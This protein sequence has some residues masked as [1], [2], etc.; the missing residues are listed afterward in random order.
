MVKMHFPTAVKYNQVDYAAH[1][2]F[3]VKDSDVEELVSKGGIVEQTVNEK[4][5][6]VTKAKENQ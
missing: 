3:N 2:S 6:K 4:P 1:V 5:K